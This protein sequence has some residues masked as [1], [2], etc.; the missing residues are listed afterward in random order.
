[1]STMIALL[2]S[3]S[4]TTML[5]LSL[6]LLLL[7]LL[8]PTMSMNENLIRTLIIMHFIK[9]GKFHSSSYNLR[10]AILGFVKI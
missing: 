9:T 5:M 7:L 2:F 6:L 10:R 1:M 4:T 8:T 3:F